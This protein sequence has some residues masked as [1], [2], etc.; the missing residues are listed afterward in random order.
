MKEKLLIIDCE[1]TAG[2]SGPEVEPFEIA[3]L[4]DVTTT[5]RMC[6]NKPIL[7]SATV[8]HGFTNEDVKTFKPIKEVIGEVYEYLKETIT[9]ETCVTAYNTSFDFGVIDSACQEYLG[10]SFAP[11]N[12]FD[13]LRLA[14]KII[15]V[16][17]SGN[18]RLDTVFYYLF[19]KE[20]KWLLKSRASHSADMDVDI[21]SRVISGLWER[22]EHV[23]QREFSTIKEL[24]D[25][26]NAPIALK[27]WPFGKHRGD[28]IA[29]VLKTDSQY[30]SWF[31]KQDWCDDNPDLVYTIKKERGE[32]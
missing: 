26:T 12:S 15:P 14:Q 28:I 2:G 6:P 22:L 17:R 18:H 16:E 4:D 29:D 7:P 30:V 5:F 20:L 8:I 31:M 1:T 25:Y 21:T 27:V 24:C 11:K 9:S 23:E 10:K 19:P 13:T 3:F 32:L